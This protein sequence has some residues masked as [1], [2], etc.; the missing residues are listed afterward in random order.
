MATNARSKAWKMRVGDQLEED[1]GKENDHSFI[2]TL[3]VLD[4]LGFLV[5][6]VY[7]L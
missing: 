3:S 4:G 2:C 5:V 1:M 6:Y 7:V